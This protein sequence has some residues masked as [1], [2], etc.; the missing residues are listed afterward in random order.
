[1][2][3]N[4][5]QIA[6]GGVGLEGVDGGDGGFIPVSFA[7]TATSV[8][9]TM[10]TADRAYIVKAIRGRVD[11]AGTDGGAVTAQ[12]RKV[13]SG[14][15]ITSGTLVHSGTY[16]LKGTVNT[17]QSITL[18]TT[19]GITLIPAG[20]SVCIDFTGVLTSAVGTVTL[21]LSPA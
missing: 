5:K 11:V 21:Y 7:Y 16:N 12:F 13:A 4:I 6:D 10:F 8:D 15:A 2:G 20:T 19:T 17:N 18:L 9:Q 1:M 3:V 14:T